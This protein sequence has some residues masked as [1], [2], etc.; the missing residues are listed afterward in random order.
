VKTCEPQ[1]GTA[2]S[3]RDFFFPF[4]IRLGV[5]RALQMIASDQPLNGAPVKVKDGCGAAAVPPS[6]L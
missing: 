5:S 1:A 4:H 3:S 2:Q 6:L